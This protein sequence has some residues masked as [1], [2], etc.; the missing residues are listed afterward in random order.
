M[1]QSGQ[2]LFDSFDPERDSIIDMIKHFRGMTGP[3]F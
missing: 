1:N 2:N 3:G